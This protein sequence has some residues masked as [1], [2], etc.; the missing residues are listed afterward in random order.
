MSRGLPPLLAHLLQ[1]GAV[2]DGETG[3]PLHFGD[4]GRELEATLRGSVFVDRSQLGRVRATGKDVLDLLHRL[5]TADLRSL[6]AGGG[7]SAVVTTAKGRIV[8]RI[9]VHNLGEG[10]ILLVAGDGMGEKLVAHFRRSIFREEIEIEDAT[11]ALCQLSLLGPGAREGAAAAGIPVPVSMGSTLWNVAGGSVHVLGEDG[12]S[13]EGLSLIFPAAAGA[14]V[15]TEL[16]PRLLRAGFLGCGDLAA[17]GWRVLRGLPASGL[18]L[19]EAHNPLEAGLWDAVSFAKGCYVGQEVVA[20]IRT[21]D[22]L[23]RSLVGLEAAEGAWVPERGAGLFREGR[24]SGAITSALVPPGRS[25]AVGLGYVKREDAEAGTWLSVGAPGS[26][27]RMQVVG[28][29][30]PAE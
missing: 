3:R 11:T 16:E 7:R 29:P 27:A 2:V 14:A 1:S 23:S 13:G 9:F 24:E 10:G 19:T 17:E 8:D 26:A 25:A 6:P 15:W 22:K 4:A 20:R 5:T 30:F 21:Y 28:L 18:E 12:F